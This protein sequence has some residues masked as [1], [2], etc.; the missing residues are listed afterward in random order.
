MSKNINVGILCKISYFTDSVLSVEVLKLE[1]TTINCVECL[2]ETG[3]KTYI[4]IG[5]VIFLVYCDVT[6]TIMTL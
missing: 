3:G 4:C 1:I 5:I 6:T 2:H